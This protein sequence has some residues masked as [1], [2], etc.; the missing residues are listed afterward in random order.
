MKLSSTCKS[1]LTHFTKNSC[2][3]HDAGAPDPHFD[4]I[5]LMLYNDI[6]DGYKYVDAMQN[7]HSI[8][9]KDIQT[10]RQIPYPKMFPLS[11]FPEEI[12]THIDE[13]AQHVV[14]YS[15]KIFNR[16]MTFH[17]VL[18]V[19]RANS[20]DKCVDYARHMLA[21]LYIVNQ[22]AR[23]SC[24]KNL[25]VYI[26]MTSLKKT[27]PQSNMHV[28]G[29]NHANTAFTTTCPVDSEIVIFR[30]EEW[31]KV[32]MHET[33]HN[34]AL[35][36]SDMNNNACH[37][38]IKSVFNV[39][40]DVNLFESYAEFWAETMNICFCSY[41][42][43]TKKT[44]KTGYLT[45]CKYLFEVERNYSVF[46]MVKV[47]AFMGLGYKNLHSKSPKHRLL[48]DTLYKEQTNILA[49]YI[50]NTILMTHYKDTIGWCYRH[51][52]SLLQ[53]KKSAANQASFCKL[54]TDNYKSSALTSMVSCYEQYL[55]GLY[56]N[57]LVNKKGNKNNKN[58]QVLVSN[59]R[60]TI[61]EL[62]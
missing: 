10:I 19:V 15:V 31:F 57:V 56:K 54:V 27:I 18:E 36:F 34:F 51:N 46:Q 30:S 11:S 17:F 1:L 49:Y 42:T 26:Y 28:L 39:V 22:Y 59:L 45:N 33:F 55:F 29:Q 23:S 40:S 14:T 2:I 20:V 4:K 50:I 12:R 24:A 47:L 7:S 16:T 9:A 8:V 21:W 13:T 53:F 52:T 58:N 60:M 43:I 3:N 6:H 62:C 61:W 25:N 32:F 5:L 38:K 35:D 37:A 44:D 41:N 48:R